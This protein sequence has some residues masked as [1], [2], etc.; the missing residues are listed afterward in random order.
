VCVQTNPSLVYAAAR[1]P[2]YKA[3]VDDAVAYGKK[4]GAKGTELLH[5][6][7]D[8]IC[9]NFGAEIL[10][11]VPGYVSTE[12]DARLSF[13]VDASLLRARRLIAMY[14]ELG[15]PRERVLIK[16]ASTWEG[17]SA[18]RILEAEGTHCNLTLL[19]SF[20]QAVACADAG[21]TLISPFGG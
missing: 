19:F 1:L 12:V 5:L 18:A 20:A 14:A 17:I 2:E 16:L 7:L 9:V 3:L 13:D 8:K 10:K 6:V 4:H 21:A 15:I 11:Y